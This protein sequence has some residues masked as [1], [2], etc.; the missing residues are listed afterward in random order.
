MCTT[1]LGT[2]VEYFTQ[3]TKFIDIDRIASS[4]LGNATMTRL[5]AILLLTLFAAKTAAVPVQLYGLNY[6][7][8]QGPDWDPDKCKNR[9][10]VVVDLTLLQKLTNRIRILS[11]AD[12]GQGEL[13]LSVAQE[14]GLQLWLGLWV[15]ADETIF[16]QE[17]DFLQDFLDRDLIGDSVLGI[18]VGSESLYREEVDVTTIIDYKDQVKAILVNAGKSNLPVSI[19]DIAPEYQGNPQLV[20][21]VDMIVTNSFPFWESVPVED[22]TDYLLEEMNPL[23]ASGKDV[24]MGET[25]WPSDGHNSAVGTGTPELQAQFFTEFFCRMD[26]E[27]NWAYFYFTGI[28]NDWQQEQDANNTIEG[29]W[30][31]FYTNFTLKE[32]FQDLVFT[33]DNDP[34]VEYTFSEIDWT[35]P[36][37]TAAP[38]VTPAPL[39]QASC[40]AHSECEGLGGNCCPND[41][42]EFLGCCDTTGAGESPTVS[43]SVASTNDSTE[44]DGSP[45]ASPTTPTAEATNPPTMAP[46]VT[47]SVTSPSTGALPGNISSPTLSPT[48]EANS[49]SG[50]MDPTVATAT[51]PSSTMSPTSVFLATISPGFDFDDAACVTETEALVSNQAVQ[52]AYSDMQTA[53]EDDLQG[54]PMTF[55]NVVDAECSI[56]I[57]AY[58]SSLKSTCAAQSGQLV[59]K[60]LTATCSGEVSGFPIPDNFSIRVFQAPLC[61]GA[62]CDPNALPSELEAQIK[63]V[64]EDVVDE[65]DTALGGGLVCVVNVEGDTTSGAHSTAILTVAVGVT[66][67]FSVFI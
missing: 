41:N 4:C 26:K 64:L 67:L 55:C 56:N 28:D 7:T 35:L 30:G 43:P 59:G 50:T 51:S 40:A 48:A 37:I 5:F 23:F 22:A 44:A 34:S 3:K 60:N 38:T 32:H 36:T 42:D 61:A 1:S 45:T 14:L 2:C 63:T 57:G 13:V 24:L 58:S 62:S 25:G 8:R 29:N 52:S 18:S 17:K 10:Q 66:L 20:D 16:L 33:C 12:C 9:E 39:D 46:T 47:P 6:N 49:E 15:S 31:I 65:I 11:L 21:A 53:L 19:C 27:L 54:N